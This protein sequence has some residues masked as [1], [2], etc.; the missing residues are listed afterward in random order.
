MRTSIICDKIKVDFVYGAYSTHG[1]YK[2]LK[3]YST[4]LKRRFNMEILCEGRSVTLKSVFK[5]MN[6]V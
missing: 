1:R 3:I 4:N 6:V 5:F 2:C